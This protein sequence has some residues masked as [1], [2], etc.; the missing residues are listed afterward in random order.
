VQEIDV[1]RTT[2]HFLQTQGLLGHQV[3]DLYTDAHPTLISHT[4]LQPFQRFTL[5]FEGF[6]THPDLVGRLHDG[7]VTF[8]IEAKGSSDL[9][10]GIAQAE[11]YRRGFHLAL[12]ASA[13]TPSRDLLSLARQRDIGVLAVF[14][15]RVEPIDL[16]PPHLPQLHLADQVR[17]QFATSD[18]FKQGYSFNLPTHYLCFAP[19]LQL[20]QQQ[21]GQSEAHLDYLEPFARRIY[22]VLPKNTTSFRAA[23][24]GAQKLGLVRIEGRQVTP[25]V[26][27]QAIAELVP[28]APTL[29]DIHHRVVGR[30]NEATLAQASP[31]SGAA[32]RCLLYTDPVVR[33]IVDV[34]KAAGT[35]QPIAM[36]GLA[37]LA[38]ERDKI[39]AVTVFFNPERTSEIIDDQGRVL[40]HRV[41]PQHYRSTTYY[42][43]KSILKHAGFLAPHPLGGSTAKH[44]DPDQDWWEL[45]V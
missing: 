24:S 2:R 36:P 40:W 1:I 43:Y 31:A 9:L 16:P 11:L 17:K 41:Q 32:L 39:L 23:L 33:L 28:D 6:S 34:L 10:K 13:G 30:G 15:D 18:V 12:F 4:H 27:G 29:A 45:Q 42:Q 26:I 35:H 14:P 8:A 5:A 22:P 3:I 21:F 38:A 7:E 44:Y 37:A 19:V 20:W 25:T